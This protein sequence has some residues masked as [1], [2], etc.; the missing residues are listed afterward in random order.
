M[1]EQ[2]KIISKIIKQMQ[3][4]NI[5]LCVFSSADAVFYSTGF[6]S[7]NL[8]SSGKVGST[9]SIVE[10]NG[11]VWLICSEFEKD[12]AKNSCSK[13]INILSYPVWIY[14]EDYAKKNMKKESQP[15]KNAALEIVKNLIKE[16]YDSDKKLGLQLEWINFEQIKYI[17]DKLS[18]YELVSCSKLLTE[19]RIKKTSWEINLLRKNAQKSEVSMNLTA[20]RIVPGLSMIEIYQTFDLLCRKGPNWVTAVSHAHTIGSYFTPYWNPIDYKV[21]RGDL[22]RLDGGPYIGGYKS[23]LGRTYAVGNYTNDERKYIYSEL[24][25]G[26]EYGVENIKPGVRMCDIFNG[27]DE[28]INLDKYNYTRGHY[29]HSISCTVDGE[30]GPFISPDEKRIFEPGMVMCLETPFYSSKEQ[31]FNIED[32]FL[33]TKKG[34][35]FFTHASPSLIS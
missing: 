6:L 14:I 25:K 29:G 11:D 28:R 35:E 34:V 10:K 1:R 33:V 22:I 8:Y 21:K 32:T 3:K 5:D 18:S 30:E 13:E 17:Q 2:N 4:S 15:N 23:D 24:W 20:K 19:A 26:F 16:N 9:F 12:S 7:R 27:I 31:T